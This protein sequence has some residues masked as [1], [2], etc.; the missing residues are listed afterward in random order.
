MRRLLASLAILLAAQGARAEA[1][2]R[3]SSPRDASGGRE[4]LDGAVAAAAAAARLPQGLIRRVIAAESGG[5]THAVSKAGALGLM[6]LEPATWAELRVRLGLGPDPFDIDDNVLAGAIYLRQLLDAFG[7]PGF[8][9]AYNL[10]PARYA[11][12]IAAGRPLPPATR[13]YL[14]TTAA[15]GRAV[16]RGLVPS[17]QGLFVPEGA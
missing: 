5:R 11:R 14:A 15:T 3:A 4:A 9:A 1:S 16:R 7:A 13:S 12:R 2:P 8:L 6:Q 10:G 17:D